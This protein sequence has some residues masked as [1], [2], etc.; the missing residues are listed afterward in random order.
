VSR[1]GHDR[2]RR[3]GLPALAAAL[4]AVEAVVLAVAAVSA[5]PLAPQ[6]S[7]AYPLGV[8]HD[9]RW[10][11]VFHRSW[12]AFAAELGA[13][14]VLRTAV[15]TAL[16]RLAWPAGAPRPTLRRQLRRSAVAAVLAVGL[17]LTPALLLFTVGV[18]SLSWPLFAAIP[19]LLAISAL[20]HHALIV[21]D[22][23][24]RLP[25]W[26]SVGWLLVQVVVV[27]A[28]AAAIVP[29]PETLSV[30]VAAVAGAGNG[31]LWRRLVAATLRHPTTERRV[32]ITPLALAAFHGLVLAGL[33]V[34]V[35]FGPSSPTREP[36]SDDRTAARARP[37]LVASGFGSSW[38]GTSQ[39]DFGPAFRAVR[40]SYRGLGPAGRPLPY[41]GRHT[42][43]SIGRL[44]DLM[45]AQVE[46]L[47]RRTGQP[48]TIVGSSEASVVARTY[49][50]RSPDAPVHEVLMLSPLLRP[51]RVYYPPGDGP[52]WGVATGW[53]LEGTASAITALTRWDLD[54]DMPMLRSMVAHAPALRY[55]MTCPVPGVEVQAIVPLAGRVAI[56]PSADARITVRTVGGFHGATVDPPEIEAYLRRTLEDGDGDAGALLERSSRVLGAAASAWHVPEL[57]IRLND[58]W[59]L[60]VDGSDCEIAERAFDRWDAE[61]SG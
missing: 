44:A 42:H 13:L 33:A 45:Q 9:L 35:G 29:L 56:P 8:F 6:V 30:P 1:D 24:R 3:A 19:M 14:L 12:P 27:M 61:A 31:L 57:P 53:L 16:M 43:R 20:S 36:P 4:A 41:E 39:V 18:A 11:L 47:H 37:V 22:W 52:G 60:P 51:S 54:P 17:L 7:A 28:A 48:V 32:P 34:F 58:A 50:G 59:D 5:S 23:W 40:F 10:L 46:V 49:L 25:P 2:A 55:G 26:R 21:D 38:D 15:D